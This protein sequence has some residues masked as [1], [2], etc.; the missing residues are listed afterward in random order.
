MRRTPEKAGKLSAS[1]KVESYI[2]E[3]IVEGRLKPRE[4]LIEDDI[5]RQLGC[6]RGP[7][8]EAV[9]RLER[10]GLIV[11][12][13]RRGTFIRDFSPEEV[14]VVFHVRGKLEALAA[15]YLRARPTAE[16]QAEL[17]ECLRRMHAAA[18]KADEEAFFHAD[19]NLHHTI[20]RLSEQPQLYRT[21]SFVMTPTFFMI[22][23]A[24][25]RHSFRTL[26]DSCRNHETYIKAILAAPVAEV[27]QT[28][29]KYF[30]ALYR[31][32]EETAFSAGP[33][34]FAAPPERRK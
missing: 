30:D 19:V 33:G 14:R 25:S 5:A 18:V 1:Q 6:S 2:Q 22:A 20:W 29:E 27:E 13:A 12:T 3:A 17:Q 15:R 24:Y 8:R 31:R 23:R 10:D 16:V 32:L 21:L 11:T 34:M 28:V 26:A 7:V 4:R 9:L